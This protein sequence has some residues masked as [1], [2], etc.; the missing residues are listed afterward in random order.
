MFGKAA[1]LVVQT[2]LSVVKAWELQVTV[3]YY[4]DRQL[5][6]PVKLQALP[7]TVRDLMSPVGTLRIQYAL[8]VQFVMPE[9]MSSEHQPQATLPICG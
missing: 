2:T 7:I 5:L 8:R 4:P 9:L 3:I 1:A 6:M